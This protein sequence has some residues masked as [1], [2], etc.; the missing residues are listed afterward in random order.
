MFR[1][2]LA[3]LFVCI[4]SAAE[5]QAG[6]Q[7][8]L[9]SPSCDSWGHGGLVELRGEI[10]GSVKGSFDR[11]S[12]TSGGR[13]FQRESLPSY[14]TSNGDDG[15]G[16][17]LQDKSG[18]SH[19]LNAPFAIALA[20][21]DRWIERRGW[22]SPNESGARV[23]RLNG[24]ESADVA[25]RVVPSGGAPV[26]LRFDKTSGQILSTSEQLSDTRLIRHFSDWIRL[27]DGRWFAQKE[28]DEEPEDEDI[29]EISFTS[30][31]PVSGKLAAM[32]SIPPRPEDFGI[33]GGKGSA[34]IAYQDDGRTRVFVPVTINGHGPLLFEIDTGGHLILTAD[35]AKALGIQPQ[36]SVN[37]LGG[38]EGIMKA[39]FARVDTVGI[40][41]AFIRNQPIK[42]LPLRAEDNDR[43]P[44]PPRAGILGLELFE[45]FTVKLD[46]RRKLMTLSMPSKR[47]TSCRRELPL[48]FTEDDPEIAGT[49]DGVPGIL[50]LDVGNA[51]PA[52]VEGH[53][54]QANGLEPRLTRGLTSKGCGVGGCY[55]DT[56]TRGTIS[57]GPFQLPGEV[58]SYSGPMKR[59]AE[60]T[61]STAVNVGEP[62]LNRFD[63]TFEYAY[64]RL[65]L[66]PLPERGPLG[67]LRAGLGFT[68]TDMAFVVKS[69]TPGSPADQAGLKPGDEIQWINGRAAVQ[70]SHA[71]FVEIL[72]ESPG[73]VVHLAGRRGQEAMHVPLLLR[74]TIP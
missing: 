65:C 33:L 71:D 37:S 69:V 60:A 18:G 39:G 40:G 30:I 11:V 45:R 9:D 43:S 61:V 63:M 2:G 27:P 26:E 73:T 51:G 16:A 66:T 32:F 57:L 52:I 23:T 55:S 36:G 35:A 5:A 53:F 8:P 1:M 25:L 72:R 4:A 59:G 15:S 74:E 24:P 68:R 48:L 14:R 41:K 67:Y 10:G 22:C 54:A 20:A 13:I 42:I 29:T 46:R 56:L 7:L 47:R 44:G 3:Y 17:W 21:S 70:V 38:G 19:R 28:V 58:V 64:D 49:F 31:R 62:V 34:T 6:Q 50:E 12:D